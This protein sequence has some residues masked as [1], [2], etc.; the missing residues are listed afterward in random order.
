MFPCQSLPTSHVAAKPLSSPSSPSHNHQHLTMA[1]MSP[2]RQMGGVGNGRLGKLEGAGGAG[3]K[4][5]GA[6]GELEGPGGGWRG[7]GG[8]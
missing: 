6:G 3:E 7:A 1:L 2:Q 4:L 5:E 8:D